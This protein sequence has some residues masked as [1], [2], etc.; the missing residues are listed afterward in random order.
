MFHSILGSP[1]VLIGNCWLLRMF[2]RT[3]DVPTASV[4]R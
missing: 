4:K 1:A 3:S 2:L